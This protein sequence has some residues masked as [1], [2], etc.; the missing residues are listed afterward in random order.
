MSVTVVMIFNQTHTPTQVVFPS[1]L[2]ASQ[3]VV[4]ALSWPPLGRT[5]DFSVK[6]DAVSARVGCL[7]T[8]L[9]AV[10]PTWVI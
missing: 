2:A 8:E 9:L 4:T 10:G 6:V 7:L 3:R 5:G 1:C